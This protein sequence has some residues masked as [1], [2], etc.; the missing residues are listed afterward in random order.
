MQHETPNIYFAFYNVHYAHWRIEP[1]PPTFDWLAIRNNGVF[2]L[3]YKVK[4]IC[5]LRRKHLHPTAIERNGYF[6]KVTGH[7]L[8]SLPV[9]SL[10]VYTSSV[11]CQLNTSCCESMP[12]GISSL[13]AFLCGDIFVLLLFLFLLIEIDGY[14]YLHVW[15]SASVKNLNVNI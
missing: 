6:I 7:I 9:W 13:F 8:L 3:K 1:R 2:V 10:L 14:I 11:S 12:I 15:R 5:V 4:S